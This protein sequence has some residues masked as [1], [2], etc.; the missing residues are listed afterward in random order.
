MP[1]AHKRLSLNSLNISPKSSSRSIVQH[2]P[3]T[4]NILIESPPLVFYG[5]TSSST[6][7]LLSGQIRLVIHDENMAIDKFKMRLA[8]EVTR[9]KPFHSHC[10]ECSHK[11]TDLTTWSFLPGPATLA[12]GEHVFPFSFLL[13]GH[14]PATMKGS[15]SSIDYVLRATISPKTG[16]PIK[17]A[18]VLNV[19]RSVNPRETARNSIR[20]F[21]PTNLTA[22][23][24]L[25]PVIYPIGET[26]VSMR[27]DGVVKRNT[28]TKT[29]THWKMKR[30]TWRLEETQKMIS[31][32]C[33]KH[34]AKLGNVQDS[35]KGV[36]HQDVRTVGADEMKGGWKADYSS[37]DGTI[38]LEFPIGI[39][40]GANPICELKAEDGTEV[41]HVLVVELIVAEEFA[42]I[43]KP[44]Q[45]T[46][47]GAARVLRMHFNMV[48]TERA[49]LG[50]SWDEEQPPLYENVPAS[51]PAYGNAEVYDGEPIPDYEDLSPLDPVDGPSSSSGGAG[52]SSSSSH[53]GSS[54]TH[55]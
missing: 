11:S 34:A 8:L 26:T 43:K 36:A 21:P 32:A 35:K 13:Q 2:H 30:L 48:V 47:T 46:P 52:P 18:Q 37:A 3:G 15:L 49:G 40:A 31:P 42:P 29:Q 5:I 50:I 6:G 51:P 19:K 25:P 24:V 4:L 28:D 9:K 7:A 1:D 16:E 22:T 38:E 45:V 12:K 41:S 39:R 55:T 17:L 23:C 33:A 20:I 54:S 53:P 14:L 44:S 10:Q 27:M